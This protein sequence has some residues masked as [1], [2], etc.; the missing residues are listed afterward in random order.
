M[1]LS[2]VT[3]VYTSFVTDLSKHLAALGHGTAQIESEQLRPIGLEQPPAYRSR[4]VKY[5]CCMHSCLDY[6]GHNGVGETTV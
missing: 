5:L 1:Y 2:F 6:E 3:D 4:L